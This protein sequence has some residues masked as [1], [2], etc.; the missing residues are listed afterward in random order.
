MYTYI[1]V[2]YE[3]CYEAPKVACF[4]SISDLLSTVK[5]TVISLHF[6][7]LDI[8]TEKAKKQYNEFKYYEK[9]YYVEI[10]I[11]RFNTTIILTGKNLD[12]AYI[13]N[14]IQMCFEYTDDQSRDECIFNYFK[15][16]IE[17]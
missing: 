10:D 7:D 9:R 15:I 4:A 6:D 8:D 16:E 11:D 1:E 13:K 2:C 5:D 14:Y 3:S 17:N 12:L